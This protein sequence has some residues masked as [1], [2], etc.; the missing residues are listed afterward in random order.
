MSKDAVRQ[1]DSTAGNN[2]DVGGNNLAEGMAPAVVNNA[3]REIMAQVSDLVARGADIASASTLNLDAEPSFTAN[4][5]GTTT[6][7]AVTLTAGQ[8]F[9]ARAVGAFQFTAS[10]SLIV[11]GSTTQNYTTAADDLLM[12][13]GFTSSVV[14]VWIINQTAIQNASTTVAGKVELAT[15]EEYWAGSD[16]SRALGVSETRD[17]A[18]EQTLTD[19]TTIAVDMTAGIN[20]TVTLGGNRTLGNPTVGD[21]QSGYIRIVQDG[22]GSRTLA[23]GSNWEFA[24]GTAPTLSTGAADEDV[25]FYQVISSTRILASLVKDIS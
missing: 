18:A 19:D 21:Q 22:T 6:V 2:T 7:T 16:T 3:I 15:T 11:N 4:I 14:R 8:W 17:A 13:W 25:L 20:F 12:F 23:Y 24:G 9:I 1:W 10:S 5:T